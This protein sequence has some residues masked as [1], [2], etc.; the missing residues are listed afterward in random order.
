MTIKTY[1]SDRV[2]M[3]RFWNSKPSSVT[4]ILKRRESQIM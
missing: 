1:V 2:H 3:H 4:L